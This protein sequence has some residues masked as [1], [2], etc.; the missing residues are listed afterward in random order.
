MASIDPHPAHQTRR[1]HN[2]V[3]D[4][5]ELAARAPALSSRIRFRDDAQA[6]P[7]GDGPFRMPSTSRMQRALHCPRSEE[8]T[9][10]LQSL[11]RTSYAV[12][13]LYKKHISHLPFLT[14]THL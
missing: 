6:D 8:R 13:C 4:G 2:V 14:H 11:I 7:L 3:G 1:R 5:L 9:S 12:F 10:E